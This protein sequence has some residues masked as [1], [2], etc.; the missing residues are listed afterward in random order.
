M[1]MRASRALC[2]LLLLLGWGGRP[3]V[4]S[5]LS[6]ASPSEIR[7]QGLVS[8]GEDGAAWVSWGGRDLLVT[9]GYMI[10]RDLR[11]TAIRQDSVVLYRPLAR[12]YFA[13]PVET[14]G[15]ADRDRMAT[16]WS[17]PLPLWKVVRMIALAYRKE[18]IC[19]WQTRFESAPR[20]HCPHVHDMMRQVV[21]PHHRFY[22]REGVFF[23]AP[24]HV[25]GQDWK[26]LQR[27]VRAFPNQEL[28]QKFPSLQRK[29]GFIA[30]GKPLQKVLQDITWKTGVPIKT[31]MPL[32]HPVYC[33]F[34]DRSWSEIL[35]HVVIFNGMGLEMNGDDIVVTMK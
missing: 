31:P 13:L 33:S 6:I 15:K 29:V 34:R 32:D 16:I 3:G 24:V 17:T 1:R 10:G 22:G 11:V 2:F 19:H 21:T 30:D 12:E 4:V 27:R 5:A 8:L 26:I 35:E 25:E 9:P 7:V 14:E 20:G 28:A 18:Y 23:V